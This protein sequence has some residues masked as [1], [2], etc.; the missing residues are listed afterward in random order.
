MFTIPTNPN[1]AP[2][3]DSN[4][5]NRPPAPLCNTG[6]NLA[7]NKSSAS[8]ELLKLYGSGALGGFYVSI[9]VYENEDSQRVQ[10]TFELFFFEYINSV[11]LRELKLLRIIINGKAKL[12][13]DN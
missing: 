10:F 6:S 4:Y 11:K 13:F 8:S 9:E 3:S 7:A 5:N 12:L 1:I 2:M